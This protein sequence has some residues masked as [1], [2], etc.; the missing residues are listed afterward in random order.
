MSVRD[1][2]HHAAGFEDGRG[3][4]E[5]RKAGSLWTLEKERQQ[6]PLEPPARRLPSVILSHA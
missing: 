2:G 3:S 6:I 1:D 5:Q 4:H